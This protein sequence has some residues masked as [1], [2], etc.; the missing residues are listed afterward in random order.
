MNKEAKNVVSQIMGEKYKIL[1]IMIWVTLALYIG[2]PFLIEWVEGVAIF[3][4]V[5]FGVA[6]FATLLTYYTKTAPVKK[7][8]KTLVSTNK[9]EYAEEII[10]G[11]YNSN[12][13][14]GFSQHLL[15]DKKTRVMVAYDDIVMVYRYLADGANFQYMFCT[16]DGRRHISKIDELTLAEFLKRRSG[17]LVG[18]SLQ[19][20]AAYKQAVKNFKSQRTTK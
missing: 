8:V 6:F 20:K 7:A 2:S 12:D 18:D 14:V 16:I 1:F 15:Y 10:S 13:R 3:L 11:D 4:C 17:I 5:I 19:N 9:L